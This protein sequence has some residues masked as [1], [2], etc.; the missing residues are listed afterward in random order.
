MLESTLFVLYSRYKYGLKQKTR[1][2]Y[3][4]YAICFGT[5]TGSFLSAE[6]I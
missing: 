6:Q 5:E 3:G 2:S 4:Q 1:K